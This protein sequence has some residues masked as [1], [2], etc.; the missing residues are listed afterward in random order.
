MAT[1]GVSDGSTDRPPLTL[2]TGQTVHLPLET[3]ATMRGALYPTHP[4]RVASLLPGSLRPL[5]VTPTGQAGVLLVSVEYH[6][7]GVEGI[8]P[9]DEFVVAVPATHNSTANRPI[10]SALT[11]PLSGYVWYMPVTTEPAR[12]LGVDGWGFPKVVANITHTDTGSMRHT[13]VTIDGQRFLDLSVDRP[14]SV[15]VEETVYSYAVT[16]GQLCHIPVQIDASIGAWPLSS[17]V[18][19]TLGTHERAR[20]LRDLGIGGRALGRVSLEGTVRIG[21][22]EPITGSDG[23]SQ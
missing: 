17:A 12:A 18:S 9:Y 8:D 19:L 7:V 5:Q 4:E 14:P 10:V 3:E 21:A 13:G 22:G 16:D 20:Q 11:G 15:P 1:D 2:S 23:D 6:H